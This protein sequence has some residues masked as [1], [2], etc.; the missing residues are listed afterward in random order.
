MRRMPEPADIGGG[1]WSIPVPIPHSPLGYTLVYA[2]ES[3]RGHVLIDAGWEHDDSWGVLRDG[4]ATLGGDVKDVYGVIVTHF[5]P[6]HAGLAGRVKEASGA[7]IAMHPADIA[8]VR[9]FHEH[10]GGTE[11]GRSDFERENLT[12]AG[13][14][15]EDM[16]PEGEQ[17]RHPSAPAIPDRELVDGALADLPGRTLRA[18]HTPGHSPGHL[19][20]HL[21]DGDRL[22]TGD[23]VLP[24]ITPH[25]GLY[26][27]D[28]PD[29]DPLGKYL[30]SLRRIEEIGAAEALP[31]H[32]YRFDG[33]QRRAKEIAD[34]HEERCAE[35]LALIDGETPTTLWTI[36]AGLTWRRTWAEMDRWSRRMAAGEAAAHVR[37]L[38]NRGQVRLLPGLPMRYVRT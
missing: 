36:T 35:L 17:G 29:V 7:W 20:L 12:K 15:A 33:P 11:Q 3:P 14:G 1:L 26:P 31:A 34:H 30:E 8:M 5:H 38:E 27:Y 9:G 24:E 4:L 21:E 18:V 19:C 23:H 32:R 22:F 6:D 37:H 2:L 16:P 10:R 13:A 28:Q 25:I